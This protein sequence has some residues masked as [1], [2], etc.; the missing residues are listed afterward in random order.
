MK[1]TTVA[2]AIAVA[3][4]LMALWGSV[5]LAQKTPSGEVPDTFK[6][7]EKLFTKKK[8]PPVEFTHKAHSVDMKI[9]CEECHHVYK[10]GKNVWKEGDPVKKCS[11]C[12]NFVKG[13][14]GKMPNLMNAFH[15]DCR[16]CHKAE[17]KKGNKKAP[18]KCKQ[19]HKK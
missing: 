6:I 16:G 7:S 10:D 18:T 19:C 12:H 2:V 17:K 13:R 3:F 1:K 5:C 14:K 11:E 15:K 8:K 9:K 4:A